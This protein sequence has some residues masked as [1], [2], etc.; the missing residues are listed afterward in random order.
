M[1]ARQ[2][3]LRAIGTILLCAFGTALFVAPGVSTAA[4]PPQGRT[5]FVVAVGIGEK[6][7]TRAECFS[8]TASGVCSLDGEICGTWERLET[9]GQQSEFAFE[10]FGL[11]EGRNV[12]A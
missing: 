7:N 12:L 2:N 3:R 10:L 1:K 11:N 8:F 4:P 5:Y 6:Y 9:E